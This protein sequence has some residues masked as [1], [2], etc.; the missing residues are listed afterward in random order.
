PFLTLEGERPE[1]NVDRAAMSTLLHR[2]TKAQCPP[3]E[4][5]G[6]AGPDDVHRIGL[7]RHTVLDLNDRH[8]RTPTQDLG[9]QT[10]AIRRQMLDD[11]EDHS[12]ISRGS[13]KESAKRFNDSD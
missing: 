4:G 8:G 10:R 3:S 9:H 5:H 2:F 1:E 11:D 7:Y 13:P 6:E 12:T